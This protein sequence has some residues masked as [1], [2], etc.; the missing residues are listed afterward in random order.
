MGLLG[1]MVKVEFYKKMS[2]FHIQNGCNTRHSHHEYTKVLA[3]A[4]SPLLPVIGVLSTFFYFLI[5]IL[6]ILVD[7]WKYLAMDIVY[8]S[9]MIYGIEHLM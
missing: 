1:Q 5:I 7:L 8:I 9:K 2:V 6:F 3:V 4:C